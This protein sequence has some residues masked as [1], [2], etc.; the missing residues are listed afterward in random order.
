M[1][2]LAHVVRHLAV[3]LGSGFLEEENEQGQD[4]EE[5]NDEG[6]ELVEEYRG[7]E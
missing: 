6:V 3:E 5:V 4:N 7:Q 1:G 2:L